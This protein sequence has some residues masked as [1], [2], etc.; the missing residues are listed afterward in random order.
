M[1]QLHTVDPLTYKLLKSIQSDSEF[2]EFVLIGGTALALHIGHRVS[3]DLDF[4]RYS[5]EPLPDMIN[6]I[7]RF[8]NVS[9]YNQSKSIL[10][11]AVDNIK[12]DFLSFKHPFI[13]EH[14]KFDSVRLASIKSPI[15]LGS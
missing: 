4:F 12:V 10:Q 8:G 14:I 11:I 7:D 3:I 1:F 6:S 15:F 13:G 9:V 2:D 5:D